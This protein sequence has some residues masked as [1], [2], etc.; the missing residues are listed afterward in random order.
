MDRTGSPAGTSSGFSLEW[1]PRTSEERALDNEKARRS[2][3]VNGTPA[4]M[5]TN[6][7]EEIELPNPK[8]RI[9]TENVR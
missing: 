8:I 7:R 5:D 6:Y 1:D 9:N 4:P 2:Q 3:G